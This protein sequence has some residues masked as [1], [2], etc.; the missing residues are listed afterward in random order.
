MTEVIPAILPDNLLSI[1]SHFEKVL[2]MVKKVQIDIVDGEYAPSKTWPFIDMKNYDLL[3]MV[4]EEEFLPFYDDFV[5]EIDMLVLHPV[6]YLSDLLSIGVRSFVI[7]IDSTDHIKECVKTIK[8]AGCNVGLG[9]KPSLDIALLEP[10]VSNI[11][12]IQCMG[13]DK[14]GFSHVELDEKVLYK[15]THLKK[16]YPHLPIQVDIGVN[17]KTSI[18]LVSAGASGLV[19]NSTIFNAPNTKEA[20]MKLKKM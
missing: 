11:D 10:F 9:I 17:E 7:H 4:R 15:I 19:S 2:G 3:R 20:I 1:Q 12:F 6:E 18:E 16:I 13:N 5:V 14:V 8:D